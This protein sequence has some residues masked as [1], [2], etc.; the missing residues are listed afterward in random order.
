MQ[1]VEIGKTGVRKATNRE[2]TVLSISHTVSKRGATHNGE[3]Q[4]DFTSTEA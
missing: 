3:Q 1:P 2:E 4:R